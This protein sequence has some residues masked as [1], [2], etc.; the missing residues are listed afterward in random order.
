MAGPSPAAVNAGECVSPASWDLE[1]LLG[2]DAGGCAAPNA[3]ASEAGAKPCPADLG[4]G[5]GARAALSL[6]PNA[7]WLAVGSERLT[8]GGAGE[9]LRDAELAAVWPAWAGKEG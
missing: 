8:A 3:R 5:F 6:P 1:L 9:E 7:C 2:G 4:L